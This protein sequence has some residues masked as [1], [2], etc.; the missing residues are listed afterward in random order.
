MNEMAPSWSYCA[1]AGSSRTRAHGDH[2]PTSNGE[3]AVLPPF[4]DFVERSS[5]KGT[6]P[7]NGFFQQAFCLF[8]CWFILGV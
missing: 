6:V 2:F 3:L 4:V 7:R 1:L 5:S 8:L